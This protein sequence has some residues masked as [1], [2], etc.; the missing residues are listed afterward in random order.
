MPSGSCALTHRSLFAFPSP[1]D[2]KPAEG[3]RPVP[4]TMRLRPN[5]AP[6]GLLMVFTAL[7]LPNLLGRSVGKMFENEPP[8]GERGGIQGQPLAKNGAGLENCCP[9]FWKKIVSLQ[10]EIA[11]VYGKQQ[12]VP[13]AIARLGRADN[14]T[15]FIKLH[16]Q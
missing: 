9:M 6:K 7:P 5:A 1:C 10:R 4:V 12:C 15:V 16:T 3:Q 2:G 14:S 13:A 8:C 11:A